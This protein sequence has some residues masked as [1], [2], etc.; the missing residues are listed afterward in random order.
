M[1]LPPEGP[2]RAEC[3]NKAMTRGA[4]HTFLRTIQVAALL[5]G[6]LYFARAILLGAVLPD[7]SIVD[8]LGRTIEEA[9]AW[10]RFATNGS[11]PGLAWTA[12]DYLLGY[13][14][15]SVVLVAEDV[16]TRI[17]KRIFVSYRRSGPIRWHW[18]RLS[19]CF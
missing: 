13:F 11:W 14:L 17:R 16:R 7:D 12:F 18:Q 10:M 8:G 9:P 2:L 6:V 3:W 4:A 19:I 15:L 5:V 1:H